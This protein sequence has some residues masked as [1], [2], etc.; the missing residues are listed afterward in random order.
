MAKIA[1]QV[2]EQELNF[3]GFSQV[4]NNT[5]GWL[6]LFNEMQN[7]NFPVLKKYSDSIRVRNSDIEDMN[8]SLNELFQGGFALIKN[9]P[10]LVQHLGLEEVYKYVLYSEKEIDELLS[11]PDEEI[12]AFYEKCPKGMKEVLIKMVKIKIERNEPIVDSS[13]KIEFLQKLF[14]V[15]YSDYWKENPENL[16]KR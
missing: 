13:H 7:R 11:K 5:V 10:L 6:Q 1:K 14:N 12:T 9:N 3:D 15:K 4:M 2:K 16:K 8:T